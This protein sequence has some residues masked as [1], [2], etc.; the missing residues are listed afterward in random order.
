VT[1]PRTQSVAHVLRQNAL[2]NVDEG[3]KRVLLIASEH[4][5]CLRLAQWDGGPSPASESAMAD[6]ISL[7]E[8]IMS[9]ID[10]H[11]PLPEIRT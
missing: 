2:W 3:R 6:A 11:W 5:C 9:K 10:N 7:A 8:R 1:A 4:T